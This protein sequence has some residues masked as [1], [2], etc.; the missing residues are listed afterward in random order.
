MTPK[1]LKELIKRK[2]IIYWCDNGMSFKLNDK[3]FIKGNELYWFEED[4]VDNDWVFD[5]EE[6]FETK[7]EALNYRGE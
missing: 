6:I 1:R 2:A 7:E 5:L 3:C 4:F